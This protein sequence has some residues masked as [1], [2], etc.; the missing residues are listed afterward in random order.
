MKKKDFLSI[1]ELAEILGISRI[2]VYKKVKTGLI[3]A[4]RIGSSYA[5]P[6]KGVADLLGVELGPQDKQIIDRAVDKT[7]KEYGEVLKMLGNE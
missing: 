3:K 5:I 2:A 7:V 1:A 4:I 6:S